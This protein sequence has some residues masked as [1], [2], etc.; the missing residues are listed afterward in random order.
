M[1][2]VQGTV[3]VFMKLVH[4]SP[5]YT[6]IYKTSRT[7]VKKPKSI[8]QTQSGN[9]FVVNKMSFHGKITMKLN[10]LFLCQNCNSRRLATSDRCS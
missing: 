5:I 8:N 3:L 1:Y 6:Y 7:L 9:D 2:R 4:D 10:T